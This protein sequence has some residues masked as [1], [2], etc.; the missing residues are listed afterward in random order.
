MKKLETLQ[1]K[2][3][4]LCLGLPPW[5][6]TKYILEMSNFSKLSEYLE[7]QIGKYILKNKQNELL[8]EHIHSLEIQLNTFKYKMNITGVT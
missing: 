6:K 3:I 8:N 7:K 4:K 5:T 1:N 2:I